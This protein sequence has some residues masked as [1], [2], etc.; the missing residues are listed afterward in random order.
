MSNPGPFGFTGGL[1]TRANNFNAPKDSLTACVNLRVRGDSLVE[2]NGTTK[3]NSLAVSNNCNILS[4]VPDNSNAQTLVAVFGN[5]VYKGTGS[6]LSA[7]DG[8]STLYVGSTGSVVQQAMVDTLNGVTIFGDIQAGSNLVKWTGSGNATT[9]TGTNVPDGMLV[10]TVNNF[11]F[12]AGGL[13][14]F[15]NPSRVFWSNVGDPTIWTSG[16]Y[17]DF[18][19]GDGDYVTSLSY[20]GTDLYIFKIN[21][22]GRLTTQTV[23]V[24]GAVTLGPLTTVF[25]GVGISK[26]RWIE[27]LPDGRIVFISNNNHVYVFDG[28]TLFD[29]SDQRWPGPNVQSILDSQSFFNL[30]IYPLKSEIWIAYSATQ[31]PYSSALIYNFIENTWTKFTTNGN[32]SYFFYDTY[33][34]K[35]YVGDNAGTVWLEDQSGNQDQTGN[36]DCT[37]T[38]SIV[39]GSEARVFVPRSFQ[40]Y[41][42]NNGSGSTG[43][44]NYSLGYDGGST[45][46]AK[47]QAAVSSG[48]TQRIASPVNSPVSNSSLQL[49]VDNA[50][51]NA[52]TH[53]PITISDEV[54][55]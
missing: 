20:I 21:S 26:A 11:L 17:V 39:F 51:A 29:I 10:K 19:V 37:Y 52:V 14:N 12:V 31:T 3:Y 6:A 36:I 7:I 1:N 54:M 45:S 33:V 27:K 38:K 8:G 42:I 18:R 4:S 49:V 50:A 16:N 46:V 15:T 48:A 47:A 5:R 35:L 28:S 23:I 9:F 53:L 22:I 44:I 41:L 24:S 2:R 13:L 40:T 43:T 34:N 32:W 55:I 30:G 25:V